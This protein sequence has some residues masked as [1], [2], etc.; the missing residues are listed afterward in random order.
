[1][2]PVHSFSVWSTPSR[3]KTILSGTYADGAYKD[4][5]I[6]TNPL[7][8]EASSSLISPEY[9]SRLLA[10]TPYTLTV[11]RAMVLNKRSLM[12]NSPPG[13]G[14]VLQVA[15]PEKTLEDRQLERM[16]AMEDS[17]RRQD[18][19]RERTRELGDLVDESVLMR[20]DPDLSIALSKRIND[21]RR[22]DLASGRRVLTEEEIAFEKEF[23]GIMS[24]ALT[25]GVGQE[26][27]RS[28]FSLFPLFLFQCVLDCL[29]D[30][31][32]YPV[33]FDCLISYFL[34]RFATFPFFYIFIP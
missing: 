7:P 15:D 24:E 25:P 22:E 28:V 20:G 31:N 19:K 2:S 27:I 6:P 11:T 32:P 9:V 3:R 4:L 10:C 18:D 13:H 14:S 34:D 30:A 26:Y 29:A 33:P 23:M 1:M 8:S 17:L 21:N 16:A 12:L 5:P